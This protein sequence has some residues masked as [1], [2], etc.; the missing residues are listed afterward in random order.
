[1]PF[2]PYVPSQAIA[3]PVGAGIQQAAS[4]AWS[5]LGD[6][7]KDKE[8]S[9]GLDKAIEG[10]LATHAKSDPEFL[11]TFEGELG[12]LGKMS[13]TQKRAFAGTLAGYDANKRLAAEQANR[14]ADN[15]RADG[16]LK[17]QQDQ[18]G[19]ARSRQDAEQGSL[20]RFNDNVR[21][22]GMFDTAGSLGMESDA[23]SFGNLAQDAADAGALGLPGV[24][25]ML[26]SAERS[27]RNGSLA[28][29]FVPPAPVKQAGKTGRYRSPNQ[30]EW[31]D[32]SPAEKEPAISVV[33]EADDLGR[34]VRTFRGTPSQYEKTFGKKLNEG[35]AGGSPAAGE[36]GPV[37]T[38]AQF[39]KLPSGAEYTGK[40]GRKYRKP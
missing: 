23:F 36:A 33:L 3:A 32:D 14:A 1:M 37:T 38:K 40:D 26:D 30:I 11:K 28:G 7:M 13:L 2:Q 34:P 29:T 4:R 17:L 18:M 31:E 10:T 19:L 8:E 27:G 12:K 15:A 20:A 22:R 16:F 5:L 6:Y 9:K 25:R 35:A 21:T 39:D 24:D